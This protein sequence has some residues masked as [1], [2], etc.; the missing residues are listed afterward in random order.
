ML[1]E[2][3]RVQFFRQKKEG[4]EEKRGRAAA[5]NIFLSL[6]MQSELQV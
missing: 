5:S 1:P 3:R 4:K 2:A 6:V